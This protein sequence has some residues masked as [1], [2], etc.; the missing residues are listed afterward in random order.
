MDPDKLKDCAIELRQL[1]KEGERW[2]ADNEEAQGAQTEERKN[3]RRSARHLANLSQAAG[4]KM[5]IAVFGPSQV[6]KSTLISA[7]AKPQKG[8]LMVDFQGTLLDFINQVNPTGGKETTGLVTRFTMD[9][10]PKSPDDNLPVCLRIYSE[11]DILKIIANTYF[12]EGQGAYKVD[13]DELAK[14]LEELARR[15]K[16]P[17]HAPTLD[18]L[19]D[20]MEYVNSISKHLASG[21]DLNRTFWPSALSLGQ[22]LDIEERARLFSFVWG[23]LEEFT[24]LY[25]I[26]Y[27]ALEKL[28]FPEYAFTS[29]KAIY[30]EELQPDGRMNSVLHVD[31]LL[32]ILNENQTDTI[33]VISP[34]GRKADLGRPVLC[35]L[36]SEMHAKVNEIPDEFLE[37]ADILDFPGYRSRTK[38]DDFREAIKK[39]EEI[40]NCFLR[41]KVAYMFQ[42]YSER[43]EIT[44]MLLCVKDSNMEIADLPAVIN[45]WIND[46]HG[47]TPEER[48]GKPICLFFVLTFF[49]VHLQ[50]GEGESDLTKIWENRLFAS[51][52]QPFDKSEWPKVWA[53]N[54]RNVVPFNNSFWLLNVFRSLNFLR[55]TSVSLGGGQEKEILPNQ[56][57]ASEDANTAYIAA[58]VRPEMEGWINSLEDAYLKSDL[59]NTFFQDPKAAWEGVINSPDGGCSYIIGKLNPILR[60]DIKTA[61]LQ[62]LAFKEGKYI[63]DTLGY[64]Y[65][66]GST[67]EETQNKR[68]L[69]ARVDKTLTK[70][71]NPGAVDR[72]QA[73]LEGT[74]WHR[75]GL[76][77][78]DLT[79]SD[80]ECYELFTRPESIPLPEK[81]SSETTT[82]SEPKDEHEQR[83]EEA[84]TEDDILALF[85]ADEPAP[86]QEGAAASAE[87]QAQIARADDKATYYRRVLESEWQAHLERISTSRIKLR[88]FGFN[89]KDFKSLIQ[90]LKSGAQRMG[91]MQDIETDIRQATTYAN[92]NQESMVWKLARIASAVISDYVNY[93]G[94]SPRR[95]PDK[96][97][98]TV[99]I[100]G[101]SYTLFEPHKINGEYP[102][103]PDLPPAY[104]KPYHTHWRLALFQ[105]MI[106]NVYFAEKTYN[107]RENERLGTIRGK[108]ERNNRALVGEGKA[109]AA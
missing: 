108:V 34:D 95:K 51:I 8:K 43:K 53:R 57:G 103:L 54:G 10:P 16:T 65:Q 40:K 92:V 56:M 106:D 55:V 12:S 30:Q 9:K 73:L 83:S 88:Y 101:K 94:F 45:A 1:A 6:G 76:M 35:A 89:E 50:R 14:A 25:F 7:L 100:G 90:E 78:R 62:S 105:V 22:N 104:E 31:R 85:E 27:K 49:N 20:Y 97:A 2:L 86:P 18:D 21:E 28:G 11:M 72:V 24:K 36:I 38:Y 26:L 5:G 91:I 61:Q 59:V 29:I 33:P 37:N 81:L 84:P 41:G 32:G 19:E 80:D 98:R 66:G 47:A 69:F 48:W 42:R 52:S 77:L 23:G 109:S 75:F 4:T 102:K 107:V 82:L 60:H 58:G 3:L 17:S 96:E 46:T 68:T 13:Q 67:E 39:P 93:L 64:F 70:L 99:A 79:F 15:Q 71:G 63:F 44:I 87:P 74:P